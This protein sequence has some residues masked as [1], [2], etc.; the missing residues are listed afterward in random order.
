MY[1]SGERYPS[2]GAM[3]AAAA[4][5]MR[6]ERD[7]VNTYRG[8]GA[9]SRERAR[10]PEELD[11][12]H[13]LVFDRLVRRAVLREAGDGRYYLDEQSWEAVRYIRRRLAIVILLLVIGAFVALVAAGVVTFGGGRAS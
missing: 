3:G 8:A 1:A 9:T 11:V 6:R 7:I 10:R 13:R 4:I 5:I 2:R 12:G